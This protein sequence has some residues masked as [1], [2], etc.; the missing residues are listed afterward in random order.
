MALDSKLGSP[1][2]F[3]AIYFGKIGE[4]QLCLDLKEGICII[5]YI[6]IK[7]NHRI[8]FYGGYMRVNIQLKIREQ[9]LN[10]HLE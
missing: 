10:F 6:Y 3:K 7:L 5:I 8:E 2:I 1:L 4:K 9:Q